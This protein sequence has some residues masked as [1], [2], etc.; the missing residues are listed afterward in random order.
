MDGITVREVSSR[1]EL[2]DFIF[3]PEKVHRGEAEWL[4]PIYMDDKLL[5]NKK[6]NKSYL[7]AEAKLMVAYRKG[8]PQGRIMG[9]INNRYN[10]IHNENHGR[11]CFMEC[12]NEPEVFHALLTAVEDWAREK[13]MTHL[14]GP[15]GFSDK[16]PQGFQIEGFEYPMFITAANNSPYMVTFIESEGY[17]KKIDLVN[18]L[19]NMPEELPEI[20]RRVIERV[21]KTNEYKIVE[22]TTKQE[23]RKVIV[24]ALELMNETFSEIYGFVPLTDREK[25]EFANRYIPILDPKF[26]KVVM[27]DGQMAGFA[28][29]MPDVS[30]G[31]R[32]CR[33]RLLPFGLLKVLRESK[34]TKKLMMMLGGVKKE[35]RGRGLDVLM[36]VKILESAIKSRMELIDSHLVLEDNHK[37]R[38]EYERVGGKVVKKFRIYQK[39]LKT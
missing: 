15:L 16:D 22:F 30:P 21:E 18:Y 17:E 33:G 3:L 34:R 19:V 9:I 5:F 26:I 2:H 39:S 24:P 27:S 38:A 35:Y 8:K 23:L 10:A 25:V 14:V 13:G 31:I 20:Y 29:G 36:G 28:V 4:P 11:F 37:M 12:Y 1:K 6:K 32:A 7:Y